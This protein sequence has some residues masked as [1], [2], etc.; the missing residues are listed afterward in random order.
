VRRPAEV[1]EAAGGAAGGLGVVPDPGERDVDVLDQALRARPNRKSTRFS[2]QQAISASRAK[3]PSPR[4]MIRTRG[5]RARICSTVR[6]TSST[7]PAEASMF[8]RLSWPAPDCGS[9]VNVSGWSHSLP[10]CSAGS[11]SAN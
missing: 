3:S 7:A 1:G 9:K 5:Q 2:S 10:S 4:R 11:V 8:E 6:P